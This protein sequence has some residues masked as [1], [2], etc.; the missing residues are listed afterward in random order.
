[1]T[2]TRE[3]MDFDAFFA[4]DVDNKP[5]PYKMFGE[6]GTIP[7]TIP[8]GIVLMYQR[9][10][11]MNEDDEVQGNTVHEML[12]RIYGAEVV[13]R[14]CL[15]PNFDTN[16]MTKVLRWAMKQYGLVNED[17]DKAPKPTKRGKPNLRVLPQ[18]T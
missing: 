11:K 3:T 10:S 8:Y 2:E 16:K 1:M 4:E 12:E 6:Q 5:I 9:L 13:E 17:E 15:N 14:W 18:E 7:P